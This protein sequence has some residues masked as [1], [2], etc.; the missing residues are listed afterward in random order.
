MIVQNR[1]VGIDVGHLHA[2]G[3]SFSPDLATSTNATI[4]SRYALMLII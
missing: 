3:I 4:V 1:M 2:D